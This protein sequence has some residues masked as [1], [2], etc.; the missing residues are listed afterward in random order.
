MC[1]GGIV[2]E[3]YVWDEKCKML[4]NLIKQA[5]SETFSRKISGVVHVEVL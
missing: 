1:H 4:W 2:S 3:F 5:L